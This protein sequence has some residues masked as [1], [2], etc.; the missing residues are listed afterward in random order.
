M[1]DSSGKPETDE[2]RESVTLAVETSSRVG[3]AALAVG[4]SLLEETRFSG[5]MQH[6]AEVFPTIETLLKR[7][8]CTPADIDQIHIAVGPGS[9]T[10][11]RIAVTMAKA[12]HLASGVSIVTV[13][14]LDVVAANLSGNPEEPIDGPDGLTTIPATIAA[15]FDAKRGQFYVSIYQW[16]ESPEGKKLRTEEGRNILSPSHLL[17]FSPS[18]SAL[19]SDPGY[20]IPGPHNGLWQKI[21][22]D[23]LITAQEI[24]DR[25]AGAGR[26]GLLGD[27]LFYHQDQ[28]DPGRTV[29]FP[30][31]YWS[32]HAANVWRLGRQKALAGRFDDPLALAPFYLRGPEVTLRKK[33]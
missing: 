6:S 13:D 9:F 25:F 31:R 33:A 19:V 20:R 30:E 26:L 5:P 28:F 21:A 23:D 15:L 29:I 17:T 11:L 2:V 24:M 14:S 18:S 16:V 1:S 4:S 3:S 32:P 12:M 7:H 27:G 8:D 10:G 22:P